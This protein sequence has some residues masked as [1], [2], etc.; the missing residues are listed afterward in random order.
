MPEWGKMFIFAAPNYIIMRKTW[1]KAF[2]AVVAIVMLLQPVSVCAA[3][4]RAEEEKEAGG[5]HYLQWRTTLSAALA[6]AKESGKAVFFNCFVDWSGACVLMDSVVLRDENLAPWIAEHFVPLR[7]DMRSEEGR[8]LAER[9][10]V[11]TYAQY[12]VLDVDGEIVH[13]ISGGA[14]AEEFR[15]RLQEALS[16]KNSLRGTKR[17]VESGEGTAADTVAYLKALRT[18]S[19]GETFARVG[20]DFAL[21]QEPEAYLQPAYWTFAVLAMRG[22]ERH[23]EY[24]VTHRDAFVAAHGEREYENMVESVLANRILPWAQ[25]HQPPT[26][27]KED[28]THLTQQIHAA[29]LPPYCPTEFLAEMAQ[30]RQKGEWLELQLLWDERG[31]CLKKYPTVYKSF[32]PSLLGKKNTRE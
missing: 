4:N 18:A 31:E 10:R 7:V 21:R 14:K 13:R 26:A 24:L 9:Y 17:R 28:L 25:G 27:T 1:E 6:D 15:E 8:E 16:E 20:K 30:L 22:S 29:Q 23:L 2:F 5:S 11:S 32:S 19:E 3:Q 12:L